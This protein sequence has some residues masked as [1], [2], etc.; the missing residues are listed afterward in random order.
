MIDHDPCIASCRTLPYKVYQT[1]LEARNQQTAGPAQGIKEL[2]MSRSAFVG[3]S[4]SLQTTTFLKRP[5]YQP[6]ST[7]TS[8][9]IARVDN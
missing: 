3:E 1:L 4:Q 7:T 9:Q 2:C 8:A 6:A 5:T